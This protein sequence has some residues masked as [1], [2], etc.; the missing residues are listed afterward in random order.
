MRQEAFKDR[1]AELRKQ[2][3]DLALGQLTTL[4]TDAAAGLGNLL[5]SSDTPARL[6][7]E[8]ICTIFDT[9]IGMTNNA[10]LKAEIEKLKAKLPGG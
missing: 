1:V 3:T 6:K 2:L 10:E 4:L 5:K 9:Y 8:T 7:L